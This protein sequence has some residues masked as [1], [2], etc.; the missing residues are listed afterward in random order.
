MGRPRLLLVVC[1]GLLATGCVSVAAKSGTPGGRLDPEGGRLTAV[2]P[3]PEQPP[4]REAL[5][6]IGD[7]APTTHGTGSARPPEGT[8]PERPRPAEAGDSAHRTPAHGRT[9]ARHRAP[10]APPHHRPAPPRARFDPGQV[11][12]WAKGTGFDPSVVRACRQQLGPG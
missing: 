6:P 5:A 2:T 9:A 3:R 7:A 11:C 10:A 8:V 4:A 12:A 1:A